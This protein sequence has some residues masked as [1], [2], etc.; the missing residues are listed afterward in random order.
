[1][2]QDLKE[3]IEDIISNTSNAND[4]I[5]ISQLEQ[6]INEANSRSGVNRK[7]ESLS[8]LVAKNLNQLK[9]T[10]Q[11]ENYISTGFESLDHVIDGFG[12]GEYV[13]VGARPGMGKTQFLINLSLNMSVDLPVLF[14]SFDLPP[15]L[16]TN[17]FISTISS[18]PASDILHHKLTDKQKK[19]IESVETEF[20]KH[21]IFI[22]D[23]C[24]NSI[25]G[26][27]DHCKKMIEEKGVKIIIV[28][29]LQMMGAGKYHRN[30]RE[31]EI[32]YISGVLRSIA[33]DFNVCV[34]ASSQLN[35]SVE[36]RSGYSKIPRLSDLR[37]S[38]AIEQDADKV[39]FL[40]RPEYY[41]ITLD[42][43]GNNL[44]G[45]TFLHIEKNKNGPLGTAKLMRD[46]DFT[47]F[48][49]FDGYKN[50]F[51]FSPSRLR[52]INGD[53]NNTDK[54]PF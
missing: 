17:R 49:S 54:M 42:E 6:L 51:S 39:I 29:D 23:S 46:A 36:G 50:S 16:L 45:V 4:Q 43:H 15:F 37:D 12:L 33:K 34:I 5:I 35:R 28:E 44:E 7:S 10:K 53:P 9:G 1:M 27:K 31:L 19:N 11:D 14:F 21:Q 32:N 30:E 22:N 38:G 3:K 13:I 8:D 26:F 41:R 18:I 52:S 25:L 20:S 2:R 40:F 24:R 47:S 48:K